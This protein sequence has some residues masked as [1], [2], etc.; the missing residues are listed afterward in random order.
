MT[1]QLPPQVQDL[2]ETLH[3]AGYSA[4]VVGGCVRDA[5]LGRTP[6]DWDICTA[7]RPD[8]IK[9]VFAGRNLLLTGEKHGTVTVLENGVPYE[10]TAYRVDGAYADHRRPDSVR[11]VGD[12]TRDL[13][14]RDFTVNAM[15]YSP[16]TGLVDRFGGR[17]DLENRCIRCVGDPDA[18]FEEDA[19]RILRAVRFAAQLDFTL[20][21][22][23]AAA[24]LHRRDTVQD[25]AAE[26][27]YTEL[28]KLLAGPA[29]GRVLA[30]HGRIL[31][32]ALPEMER[33]I[34]CEQNPY[35]HCYD[36]WGHTAAAVGALA[37]DAEPAVRWAMLLHD[38][39]KP[40]CIARDADGRPHFYGHNQRGAKLA[41]TVLTR[42]KAPRV[43]TDNVCALVAAH[44]Y[45]LPEED[46]GIL[47]MLAGQGPAFLHRLCAVKY[48]DLAAHRQC[49]PT[50]ARI[51]A[52]RR[53]EQRMD[54]LEKNHCWRLCDLAV[55][56]TD[57][58]EAGMPPGP[59]VGETLHRLLDAV[60][61]GELPNERGALLQAL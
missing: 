11:F 30:E 14:R 60:M 50:E 5:L 52:V 16:Q 54:F 26:R 41:R 4:Y 38:L 19:L 36:V 20:D 2:L 49:G 46:S 58:L 7:A 1:L 17:Q 3:A 55:T 44:D 27:V 9:R 15:A 34:G 25:L 59:Q 32:G 6:S 28:D 24:A 12:V 45:P 23:A 39:A 8:E 21:P 40:D 53:F 61:D 35:W 31:A 47:R 57:L 43:L 51:G 33:C 13:A 22:A 37:E 48:A 18:R 10:I 56:G 42:L 29:A